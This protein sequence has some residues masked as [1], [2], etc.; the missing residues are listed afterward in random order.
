M[1]KSEYSPQVY[2][3]QAEVADRFRVTQSTVLNWRRRGLLGYFQAPGSARVLYP[4]DAVAEFEEQS[5][6]QNK[7]VGK[8]RKYQRRKPETSTIPQQEWRV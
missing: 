4:S 7:E 1:K 5:L 2:L 6:H 3:T 8:Q